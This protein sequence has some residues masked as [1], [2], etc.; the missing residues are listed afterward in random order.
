MDHEEL[1][2][3]T[4]DGMTTLKGSGGSST[5]LPGYRSSH[6]KLRALEQ[7]TSTDKL[8]GWGLNGVRF[9]SR[10]QWKKTWKNWVKKHHS[11]DDHFSAESG[12]FLVSCARQLGSAPEDSKKTSHISLQH[13]RTLDTCRMLSFVGHWLVLIVIMGILIMWWI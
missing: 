9:R 8:M 4:F 2:S 13:E 7:L 10:K 5:S 3:Q 6:C 1:L 12:W 11:C